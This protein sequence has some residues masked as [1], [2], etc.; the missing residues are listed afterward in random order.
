MR[1]LHLVKTA[2]GALWAAQ[3]AAELA[4]LGVEVHVALP[5]LEGRRVPDWRA[6][7]ASLHALPLDLRPGDLGRLPS[8]LAG[9][10][11]LVAEVAPDLIH[12][13]FLATTVL[14][15]WALGRRHP[16]PR[17]FQVPGPLHLEHA[18]FRRL[19]LGSAGP[20]DAWIASSRCIGALYRRAGVPEARLHLSY[21]GLRVDD[22]GA[23]AD[24]EPR[25]ALRAPATGRI[26]G[27]ICFIYPPKRLLGQREG[28]KGHEL[29]L[30][31]L[32]RVCREHPDVHGVLAGGTFAGSAGYERRLRDRAA[33]LGGGR[34]AM[35]G[36]IE[37]AAVPAAWRAFDCVLHL[38]R[39]ENCGGVVEP[40]L[41]GVPVVAAAVGGLPEV[42]EE[43]VT[44]RLL[45]SRDAAAAARV[46][47]EVLAEPE[48]HRELAA[49]GAAR[50]REM[51]DVRRTAGEILAVYRHVLDPA[52]PRPAPYA[53]ARGDAP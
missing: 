24:A 17:L 7:G 5:D 12:S 9:L 41:A 21:Y 33:R 46:V 34:I 6:A 37:A 52:Q 35:P 50:A 10:R 19:D 38:P 36:P 8:Q 16:V 15:R 40:L 51:F 25:R 18:A 44:G 20:A 2:D 29:L 22:F 45:P 42:V 14:A 47:G 28:L 1:V 32:D 3:Q 26:V 49:R 4:R 39:S 11:R 23:A 30:A 53:P 48:R 13:H 43:G 31:V 27:N